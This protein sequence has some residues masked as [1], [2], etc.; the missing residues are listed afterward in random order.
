METYAEYYSEYLDGYHLDESCEAVLERIERPSFPVVGVIPKLPT[1]E[2]S[3]IA[4]ASF[5]WPEKDSA[6]DRQF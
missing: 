5:E 6:S 2:N 4:F 3:K 1:I